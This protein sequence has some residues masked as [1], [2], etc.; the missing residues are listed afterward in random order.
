MEMRGRSMR[1]W[2][3]VAAEDVAGDPELAEWVAR[4]ATYARTLP[5]K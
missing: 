4:G 1:G 3:R 2:L 5:A